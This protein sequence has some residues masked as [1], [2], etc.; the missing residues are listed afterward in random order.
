MIN[1]NMIGL[2]NKI[3]EMETRLC[4]PVEDKKPQDSEKKL[5]L[6]KQ[7]RNITEDVE[8]KKEDL[9]LAQIRFNTA[10]YR[11]GQD[12]LDFQ[13]QPLT[14]DQKIILKHVAMIFLNS[15]NEMQ[16]KPENIAKL[17]KDLSRSVLE[18][19]ICEVYAKFWVA[20]ERNY[21]L[22]ILNRVRSSFLV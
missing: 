9:F 16:H 14:D 13:Y 6:K 21:T 5:G 11:G 8:A 3:F 19:L 7:L 18:K 20:T 12:Q 15:I 2:I 10:I 22:K 17:K 1:G 4:V